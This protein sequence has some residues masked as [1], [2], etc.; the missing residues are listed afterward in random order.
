M[1]RVSHALVQL[2]HAHRAQCLKLAKPSLASSTTRSA[3]RH[4]RLAGLLMCRTGRMY[5]SLVLGIVPLASVLELMSAL[6]AK[7]GSSS[8][9]LTKSV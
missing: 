7:Q 9:D 5:A 2:T 3:N 8:T 6:L 1:I 4:A